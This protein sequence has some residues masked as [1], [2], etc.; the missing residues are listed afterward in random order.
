MILHVLLL[1]VLCALAAEKFEL[2]CAQGRIAE[3][4]LL[5]EDGTGV[6]YLQLGGRDHGGLLFVESPQASLLTCLRHLD[7]PEVIPYRLLCR[8]QQTAAACSYNRRHRAR[9]C[10]MRLL[11]ALPSCH[12]LMNIVAGRQLGVLRRRGAAAAGRLAGG[13]LRRRAGARRTL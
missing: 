10:L 4:G 7:I 9:L 13:R 12:M 3:P 6:R 11:T 1:H 8:H 5:G 2:I